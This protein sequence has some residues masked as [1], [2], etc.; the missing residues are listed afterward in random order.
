MKKISLFFIAFFVV[1][2]FVHSTTPLKLNLFESNSE[3]VSF[4][5]KG[6]GFKNIDVSV[7]IGTTAGTGRC[8]TTISASNMVSFNANVGEV[9]YDSK[10]KRIIAKIYREL[11]GTTI[12]LAEYY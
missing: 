1:L 8:C 12:N 7:G 2:S 10:N 6:T 5:V 4:R 3:S 11:N 9:L